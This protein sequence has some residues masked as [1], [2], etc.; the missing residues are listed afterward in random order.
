MCNCAHQPL[1]TSRA[2]WRIQLQVAVANHGNVISDSPLQRK[3][4]E[5]CE[6]IAVPCRGALRRAQQEAG[7]L[8]PLPFGAAEH[9]QSSA[10][11]V[12][13]TP[14]FS[15]P[16]KSLSSKICASDQAPHHFLDTLASAHQGQG[17]GVRP[18]GLSCS[19]AHSLAA[20]R[21]ADPAHAP[22][23]SHAPSYPT[24]AVTSRAMSVTSSQYNGW[25]TRMDILEKEVRS[26]LHY[27]GSN[28]D[29]AGPEVSRASVALDNIVSKRY[30]TLQCEYAPC[31][32]LSPIA[33]PPALEIWY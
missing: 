23:T 16:A 8:P 6:H 21:R 20:S 32:A 5:T 1:V 17:P 27:P 33:M 15:L 18:R 3:V 13:K 29:C 2:A 30:G 24:T 22:P 25:V 26:G 7:G 14:A 10:R 31:Q 11:S 4:V 9:A 19:T 12:A 28:H